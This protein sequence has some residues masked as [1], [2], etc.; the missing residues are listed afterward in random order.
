L[1][2]FHAIVLAG[3]TKEFR[4]GGMR[5]ERQ[6]LLAVDG[7]LSTLPVP[8]HRQLSEQKGLFIEEFHYCSRS[9]AAKTTLFLFF[10]LPPF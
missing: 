4:K 5:K 7:G 3:P 9:L 10:L 2:F 8:Q 1:I 6:P